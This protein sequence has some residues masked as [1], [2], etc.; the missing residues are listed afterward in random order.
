[1]YLSQIKKYHSDQVENREEKAEKD[2]IV[3]IITLAY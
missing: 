3:K 2:E 1:M